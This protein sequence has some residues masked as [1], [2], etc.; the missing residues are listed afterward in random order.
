MA[1]RRYTII[2]A[3]RTTGV[4]RRATLPVRPAAVIGCVILAIPVLIGIGAA[5][6]AKS[7]VADLIVSQRTLEQ[8]N[9]N[10]RSATEALAGQITSLQAAISDL[11]ARS[12]LDPN[13]SRAMEKLPRS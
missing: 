4:V 12:A 1:S 9:A 3:D 11:G 5:W 10:F 2:V 7:D 8:E 6:K 13:L